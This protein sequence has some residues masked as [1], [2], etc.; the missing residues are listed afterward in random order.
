MKLSLNWLKDYAEVPQDPQDLK[1]RLTD[2][3]IAVESV[4]PVGDD[5][6]LDA[7][8]A[9]N[10]PDC[11]CH[12]G[13]AREAAAAYR[14][15]LK[16]IEDILKESGPATA[17]EVAV[18]IADPELCARYCA[19][20][21]RNVEVKAS[22]AWLVRRLEAVG[23]RSI[24]NVADITNYVL[25]DLGQ[26][27]HAFDLE[28]VG[29]HEIHVRRAMPGETIETLDGV[30]R[31]LAGDNL[32]IADAER[33]LAL[34]G[35]M[36]GARSAISES[37]NTVLI[38]SAWF[39][40]LSIRR[41]AKSLGMHTE[42]SH[43]FERGADIES[44]PLA[45]ERAAAMMAE[46]AGG[47]V[48]RGVIDVYPRPFRRQKLS[49]SRGEIRRILGADVPWEDVERVLR[50]LGFAVDRHG[51]EGWGVIPPSFRMDVRGEVDLTE[52][53]AR[54]YGYDRLPSRLSPAPP[55]TQDEPGRGKEIALTQRLVSLGYH[56]IVAS[57]MIDPE[58][59][60]RFSE[61]SPVV[62]ENPLSKEASA[63]RTTALPSMI[64]VL[65]WNIDRGRTDLQL[66]ETGKVYW[67]D[68]AGHPCERRV[69][70][71][72][73]TGR[74]SP[75]RIGAGGKD[76]DFF[77]LKGD[78][79][80][81]FA[82]FDLAGLQFA[83]EQT[84]AFEKGLSG[85]FLCSG[86]LLVALGQLSANHAADYKLR[87]PVFLAQI[88]L[89]KLLAFPLRPKSF[90]PFSRFPAVERD[91]SLLVPER[92]SFEDVASAL[93]GI[94]RQEITDFRPVELFRGEPLAENH[95][96]LLL[97]VTLQSAD[98]TLVGDEITSLSHKILNT[99]APLGVHLRT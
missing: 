19:R 3:G 69:L 22:P 70:A 75:I 64:S 16:R 48:L 63:L 12:Y 80:S 27:L 79:E 34:A 86:S 38:E 81:L 37:T 65:L 61:A 78:V 83:G 20:V 82:L 1:R 74:D 51:T 66:F 55:R 89:E 73:L 49:L 24:N 77:D 88:D 15:P 96:G 90:H 2:V 93:R 95:Y 46:I 92:L 9:S 68:S 56:E 54:H 36:G 91:F 28:R 44:A 71:M 17:G 13:A 50:A 45:L 14:K 33:P 59:N 76:L 32:V 72:G 25:M 6:I 98:H 5:W 84:G 40:P 7:E 85:Q 18:E 35:V 57:S 8:I 52:E 47:E 21:V 23:F 53:V 60:L 31:R 29:R 11:L 58:E 94:A 87:Q 99:L 41:T 39:D 62:L 30:M 97:R 67:R 43:R 42:A 4:S 26:P 10:R